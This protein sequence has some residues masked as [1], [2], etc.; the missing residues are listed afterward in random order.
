MHSLRNHIPIQEFS[1]IVIGA[2][3]CLRSSG[4]SEISTQDWSD[5]T[6][7]LRKTL[8]EQKVK[9]RKDTIAN[10]QGRKTVTRRWLN[11][12]RSFPGQLVKFDEYVATN[13]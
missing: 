7:D 1:G 12:V 5:M 9:I 2:W 3:C 6:Q 8:L 10:V 11:L 13:A 4:Q